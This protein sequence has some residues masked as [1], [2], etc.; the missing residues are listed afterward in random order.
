M[1]ISTAAILAALALASASEAAITVPGANGSDG[2]LNVTSNISIDLS[3][4]PNGAWDSTSPTPG[5]GVYDGDKGAVVFH[6]SSV[7]MTAGSIVFKNH[8]SRASVVWLVNGDV[9]INGIVSLDGASSGGVSPAPEP[10]PGGF[11]GGKPALTTGIYAGGEGPGWGLGGGA[12]GPQNGAGYAGPG[13]SGTF[14]GVAYGTAQV[15]PLIGGSGGG[16]SNGVGGGAGGGAILI[17]A[18]GTITIN[19]SIRANGGNG[20]NYGGAGN[21]S[22]S[23]SGGAIRLVADTVAGTGTINTLGGTVYA[24]APGRIRIEA[25]TRASTLTVNPLPSAALPS[26]PALIWP[27][28]SAPSVRIV[29]VGSNAVPAQPLGELNQAADVLPD[30]L[31]ASFPVVVETKNVA[32]T[33][34]VNLRVAPLIGDAVTVPCAFVSG[35]STL[36][37][38]T[39]SVNLTSGSTSLQVRIEP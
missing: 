34:Q 10:G 28:T 4:A 11:A 18:T 13:L 29:S 24:G 5:K 6:Y 16:G 38:W 23:G 26:N 9:T 21:Q 14:P 12:K 30:I 1:H 15:V 20:G 36:A 25:N 2:I 22:G 19:G 31:P 7:S 37:T 32:T 33:A 8:P 3:Q 27:D 39:A 17:A 35:T